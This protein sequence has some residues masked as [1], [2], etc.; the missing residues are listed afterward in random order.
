MQL[1]NFLDHDNILYCSLN[2]SRLNTKNVLHDVFLITAENNWT[3]GK[4][5]P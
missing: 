1:T 2:Y 5:F 4:N 3:C